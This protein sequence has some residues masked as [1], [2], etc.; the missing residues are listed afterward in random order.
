MQEI[1]CN[2][3]G[4]QSGHIVLS[5]FNTTGDGLVAALQLLSILIEKEKVASILFNSFDAYPQYLENIRYPLGD[6]PLENKF[7]KQALKDG[8]SLING[9]GRLLVRKSGTEPMIRVMVEGPDVKIIK[10][11]SKD[12]VASIRESIT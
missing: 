3:G 11:I 2:V 4:E 6:Q 7:V 12:I 5:D 10:G 9:S 8:E 1:G